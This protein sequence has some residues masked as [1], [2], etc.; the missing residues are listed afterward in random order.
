MGHQKYQII[1]KRIRVQGIPATYKTIGEGRPVLVLHG[2]GGSSDTW[3]KF[4]E[5]HSNDNQFQLIGLDL[6]GFG[7]TADPPVAWTVGDYMHF[8]IDFIKELGLQKVVLVGHSFGGR[9][10]IKL[11]SRYPEMLEAIVLVAA[12]G[13]RHPKTAKQKASYIL[14][15]QGKKIMSSPALKKY[16]DVMR[17]LLYKVIREKDYV[18]TRGVMKETFKKVISEDLKG[19]LQDISVPTLIVW[20]TNDSY[21]PVS[22][23]RVMHEKIRGSVLEIIH[24]ARHGIHRDMPGRLYKIITHFIAQ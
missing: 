21:V 24:G 4:L 6:P 17:K 22:D 13:I 14:A 23:A 9:I 19:L 11:A 16:E 12:A 15:K 3:R 2:W 10:S 7:K 18:Q 8:V 20:G 5:Q 1:E